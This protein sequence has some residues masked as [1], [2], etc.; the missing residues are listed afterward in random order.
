MMNNQAL[1]VA[2][3][4]AFVAK[5]VAKDASDNLS[6]AFSLMH[7][8]RY[9]EAFLL[10]SSCTAAGG[11]GEK[12]PAPHFALGLCRLRACDPAGAVSCF[13]QALRL[14][15]TQ[16]PASA[17]ENATA[18]ASAAASETYYKLA[19]KQI[20]A[21]TYLE[22]MDAGFCSLFPKMARQTVI[23]ALIYAHLKCENIEQAK[24]LAAGLTG[25]EFEDYRKTLENYAS[26]ILEETL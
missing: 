24:R 10:L 19:A 1:P 23:L 20:A 8:G 4:C 17:L 21:K 15:K 5:F 22:P 13:E 6:F 18:Q 11:M 25:K 9:A 7:Q 16:T 12:E 2:K 14:I 3:D 26:N